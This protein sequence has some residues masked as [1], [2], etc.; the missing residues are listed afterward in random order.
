MRGLVLLILLA[1]A[2]GL[3]A[4]WQQ[5]HLAELQAAR[6]AAEAEADGVLRSTPNGDLAPG[7]AVLLVGRPSGA[8]PRPRPT[9]AEQAMP[10]AAPQA[11]SALEDYA[12][13][14]QPGQTL[15]GIAYLHYQESGPALVRALAAYNGLEDPDQLRAGKALRLPPRQ[16]LEDTTSR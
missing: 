6:R 14:V 2:F 15:S 7:Q 1:A 4:L 5:R 10:P 3:A 13:E 16:R 8:E 9:P 12:L 11:E